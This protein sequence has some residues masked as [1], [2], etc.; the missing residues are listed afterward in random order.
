MSYPGVGCRGGPRGQSHRRLSHPRIIRSQEARIRRS[1]GRDFPGGPV[2][3]N[4]LSNAGDVSS[5]P[6]WEAKI[7]HAVE[8]LSPRAEAK[9][10]CHN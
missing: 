2:V 7:P 1:W 8:Q 5:I 10:V 6:G 3:E 4:M 9:P